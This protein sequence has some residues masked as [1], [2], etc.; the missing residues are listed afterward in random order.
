M[1]G[2]P[3]TLIGLL[4]SDTPAESFSEDFSILPII[5]KPGA[6]SRSSFYAEF[7]PSLYLPIISTTVFRPPQG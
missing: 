3:V 2:A 7:L 6:P 5:P 1:L 4:A